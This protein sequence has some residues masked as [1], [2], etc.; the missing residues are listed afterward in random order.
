MKTKTLRVF[1]KD[2]AEISRLAGEQSV[3]TAEAV[4]SKLRSN[5]SSPRE[6][7]PGVTS[8][9]ETTK[10]PTVSQLDTPRVIL[11]ITRKRESETESDE[12]EERINRLEHNHEVIAGGCP[13]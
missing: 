7:T 13:F 2:H 1:E 8:V 12:V 5:T 4:A 6:M 11:E 3:S 9:A 10:T